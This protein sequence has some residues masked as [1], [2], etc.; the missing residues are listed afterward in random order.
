MA[1][2]AVQAP[3]PGALWKMIKVL[4]FGELEELAGTREIMVPGSRVLDVLVA[5]S[6]LYGKEFRDMVMGDASGGSVIILV[7][8][9]PVRYNVVETSLNDGDSV[10]LMPMLD[11]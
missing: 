3:G 11:V 2:G 6:S 8:N 9:A 10:S 5:L 4:L 1:L 7:N